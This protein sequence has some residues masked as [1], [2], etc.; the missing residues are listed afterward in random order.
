MGAA[1]SNGTLMRHIARELTEGYLAAG[2]Y[3]KNYSRE[4]RRSLNAFL[5]WAAAQGKEDLAGLTKADLS[6]FHEQL[7]RTVSQ[8]TG[9]LLVAGSINGRFQAVKTMFS[10]LYQ[11]GYIPANPLH[12]L[13]L[14]LPEKDYW[15][16]RAFSVDEITGFLE[17]L[18]PATPR[19][20][21]DRAL[22]EL[23]YST[24]LRALEAVSLTVGALDFDARIMKVRGKGSR[25][26]IVP[27]SMV[28]R[29]FLLRYLGGRQENRDEYVFPGKKPGRHINPAWLSTYFNKLL[30]EL[31]LKKPDLCLHSIR[32]STA[33]HLLDNGASIRHVQELLGHSDI[34]TTERY[35]HVQTEGLAKVYRRFHPREHELF[36][37]VD[38]EYIKRLE[39]LVADP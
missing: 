33:T 14:K 34:G 18:D 16:R 32:H 5:D 28:A 13:K 7:C 10:L 35:T 9:R 17:S 6:L 26:R 3:S 11:A 4:F 30:R 22:F 25:D 20:L 15:K 27:F 29:D 23:I 36:E 19:G 21:R 39:T 38:E 12:T 8:R 1:M 2:G 24:G 31:D 37:A